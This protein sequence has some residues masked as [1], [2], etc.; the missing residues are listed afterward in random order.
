MKNKNWV[1]QTFA[2]WSWLFYFCTPLIAVGL[3]W[4]QWELGPRSFQDFS[5]LKL[6]GQALG[7]YFFVHLLLILPLK[8]WVW[9][10]G[11]PLSSFQLISI[12]TLLLSLPLISFCY[13][14]GDVRTVIQAQEVTMSVIPAVVL[15]VLV[16][17]KTRNVF[18]WVLS[19]F[20]MIF[21]YCFL[22]NEILGP[23]KTYFY[24]LAQD[25]R[26]EYLRAIE[27]ACTIALYYRL[28]YEPQGRAL[29]GINAIHHAWKSR[30]LAKMFKST[31]PGNSSLEA[32][33][34]S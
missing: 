34:E 13:W 26:F 11:T 12:S 6:M 2:E 14:L 15:S 25:Y 28:N 31:D 27:P 1:V 5:I 32:E 22:V 8:K 18:N 10:E 21:F 24:V 29:S 9:I 17:F 3:G 30:R 7:L 19:L 4:A 23:F 20:G 33:S 16:F